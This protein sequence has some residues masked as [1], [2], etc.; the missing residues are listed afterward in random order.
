MPLPQ[1]TTTRSAGGTVETVASFHAGR[2]MPQVAILKAASTTAWKVR[3]TA[4]ISGELILQ[5]NKRLLHRLE[6]HY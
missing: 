5:Y 4:N 3:L 6:R 2:I 1:L